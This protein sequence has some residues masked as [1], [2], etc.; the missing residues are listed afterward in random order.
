MRRNT[1]A[2]PTS[3]AAS[4]HFATRDATMTKAKALYRA[5]GADAR[6]IT[7]MVAD[8]L[9][10]HAKGMWNVR[11]GLPYRGYAYAASRRVRWG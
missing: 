7:A 2:H 8:A 5:H 10:A 9:A 4:R 3:H 1:Y 6:T 11:N